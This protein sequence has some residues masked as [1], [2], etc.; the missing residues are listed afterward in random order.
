MFGIKHFNNTGIKQRV[1][2]IMINSA[3]RD[4]DIIFSKL[5]FLHDAFFHAS[6]V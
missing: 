6:V 5:L 1:A 4:M 3:S 2:Q